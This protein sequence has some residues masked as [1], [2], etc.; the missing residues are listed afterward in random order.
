MMKQ[1][2]VHYVLVQW[3]PIARQTEK[4]VNNTTGKN[5]HS[6]RPILY[7]S[8]APEKAE[9]P[10]EPD[11]PQPSEPE[12]QLEADWV[13]LDMGEDG[14]GI[15]YVGNSKEITLTKDMEV[16]A[17]EMDGFDQDED[18]GDVNINLGENKI[19]KKISDIRSN[20]YYY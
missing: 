9:E 4:G 6:F 5:S 20:C 19:N 16:T 8:P 17:F 12:V 7:V 14:D 13:Y 10:S 15:V 11:T 3:I 2:H 18:T 1:S